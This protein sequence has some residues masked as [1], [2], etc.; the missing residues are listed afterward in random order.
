MELS[1]E[2]PVLDLV[3]TQGTDFKLQATMTDENGLPIDLTGASVRSQ[4][5]KNYKDGKDAGISA[6]YTA[7]DAANGVY[8]LLFK[9][10]DTS[11]LLAGDTKD[12]PE[13][14]HYWDAELVSSGG[15]VD[16]IWHGTVKVVKQITKEV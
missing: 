14:E 1:N 8:Q 4:I 5:R 6:E 16:P 12:S 7:I 10:G 11:K 9:G 15:L 3:I 2:S 13:S